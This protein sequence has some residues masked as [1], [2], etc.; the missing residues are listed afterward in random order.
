MKKVVAI[1]CLSILLAGCDK[2]VEDKPIPELTREEANGI[3][4]SPDVLAQLEKT[5][6]TETTGDL[7]G[8]PRSYSP[9]ID[10]HT[11][12]IMQ[13]INERSASR[14]DVTYQYTSDDFS[15]GFGTTDK[16]KIT[17]A[18]LNATG[19]DML[20]CSAKAEFTSD[21]LYGLTFANDIIYN[22]KKDNGKF[23]TDTK[24]SFN[25]LLGHKI[26][27]TASQKSWRDKYEGNL[28]AEENALRNIP[29]SEYKIV[30]QNDLYYIYFSQSSR[31]FS[32]DELMGFFSSRWNS[33]TDVFAK[34]DIKKEEIQKIKEKIAQ[35]KDLKNIVAYSSFN[36]SRQLEEKYSVQTAEGE[37]PLTST[38]G[39]ISASD[40]Y[41]F[42][43]KGFKYNAPFC[44]MTGGMII[45]DRGIVLSTDSGLRGC[46]VGVPDDKAREV[47][48]K[49]A[50]INSKGLGVSTFVKSY[51]HI[52]KVDGDTNTLHATLIR[53][54]VKV[55]NPETGEVIIDT[56]VK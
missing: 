35:Y 13:D 8:N 26:Q 11:N 33:T 49:L 39:W 47:S 14:I 48:A 17:N 51:I 54:N 36:T 7:K 32:D 20:K 52:D 1:T 22:V 23:V 28:N 44:G 29:D 15:K 42:D 55:V 3:C 27:P 30:S 18:E 31:Q 9:F 56:I 16:L 37:K 53:D 19:T 6:K 46:T 10:R 4:Q 50:A 40:S 43:K 5:F 38:T 45:Q 41:N 21:E 2:S 24:I 25:S 34:A 12:G